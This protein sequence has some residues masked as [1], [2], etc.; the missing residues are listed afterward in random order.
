[1]E[2]LSV[3][4]ELE[5]V[6]ERTHLNKQDVQ[7]KD[8]INEAVQMFSWKI[9]QEQIKVN[10]DL[11]EA[12]LTIDKKAIQQVMNNLIDNAIRYRHD[13]TP[14]SIIGSLNKQMYDITITNKGDAISVEDQA[15]LFERFFRVESSRNRKTGGTG[16]GL[17]IVKEIIEHHHGE[18]SVRS[19]DGENSITV[20][21]PVK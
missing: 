17:A 19:E 1:M 8:V 9:E 18:V 21:L 6:T 4:N 11:A 3:L 14:I 5:L 16:L 15:Q 7:I 20:R 10:V 2:Q 13:G 12:I